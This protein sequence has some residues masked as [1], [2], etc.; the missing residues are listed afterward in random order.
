MIKSEDLARAR[1]WDE[2]ICLDC[3]FTGVE[4]EEKCDNCGGE[5]VLSPKVIDAVLAK[6]EV[7]DED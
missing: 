7:S 2:V 5:F 6:V 4:G 3:G 1:L